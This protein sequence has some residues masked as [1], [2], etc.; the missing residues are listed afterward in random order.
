MPPSTHLRLLECGPQ[1][2]RGQRP[3]AVRIQ[4][5]KSLGVELVSGG[6]G[7]RGNGGRAQHINLHSHV[8]APDTVMRAFA[9]TSIPGRILGSHLS[10]GVMEVGEALYMCGPGYS[11]HAAELKNYITLP[12]STCAVRPIL[13]RCSRRPRSACM[14]IEPRT[15]SATFLA[16]SSVRYERHSGL[17]SAGARCL[18]SGPGSGSG[19]A[20]T[21]SAIAL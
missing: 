15:A 13:L 6:G 2:G 18:G 21:M 20:S 17:Y 5:G 10:Q 7:G 14:T 16:R 1:L 19:G 8:C 3:V 11:I 12:R 9:N 4:F